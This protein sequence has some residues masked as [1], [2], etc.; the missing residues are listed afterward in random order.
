M[1][2]GYIWCGWRAGKLDALQRL[3]DYGE[4]HNWV[5]G[6]PFPE[7]AARVVLKPNQISLLGQA[8]YALSGGDD[9]REYRHTPRKY[10]GGQTDY[11]LHIQTLGIMLGSEISTAAREQ[12]LVDIN[13]E[14][15]AILEQNAASYPGDALVQA[16]LGVY[17]GDMTAAVNLLMSDSYEYPSYVRGAELYKEAHWLFTASLVL[18]SY[19]RGE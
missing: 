18:R 8:L 16:A 1:L 9:N 2:L 15:L 5:M 4:A 17:T 12:G 6:E 10:F 13:G 3:A 7:E 11:E 19:R 14:E